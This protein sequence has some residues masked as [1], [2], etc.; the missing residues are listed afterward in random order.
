MQLSAMRAS[1][2]SNRHTE[3]GCSFRL[4]VSEAGEYSGLDDDYSF[5]ETRQR[6][7][8]KDILCIFPENCPS[9]YAKNHYRNFL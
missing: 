7:N 1:K 5:V 8:K 9:V 6:K 4:R 2:I 3:I